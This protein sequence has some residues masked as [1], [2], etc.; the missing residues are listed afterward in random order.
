MKDLKFD[1]MLRG[2]FVCTM[3]YRFCPLFPLNE[4]KLRAWIE[5]QRPSLEG[6]PYIIAF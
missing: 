2:R 5:E 4:G 3:K 1:I 6:E